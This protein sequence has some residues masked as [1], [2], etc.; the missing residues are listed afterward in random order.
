MRNGAGILLSVLLL[1]AAA[2]QPALAQHRGGYL[3][4][5]GFFIGLGAGY[6]SLG[7]SC[8]GCSTDR[9]GGLSGNLRLGGTLN[10]HLTAGV[11][12]DGFTKSGGSLGDGV[13]ETGGQVGLVGYYYPSPT[14]NVYL[15]GSLGLSLFK[16][17]DK[18][19]VSL[20]NPGDHIDANGLGFGVGVGYD[21]YISRT[22]S[23]T[24]YFNYLVALSGN[25]KYNGTAVSPSQT[26]KPNMWQVG[27][28]IIWH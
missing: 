11:E 13:T 10:P 2:S 8:N 19:G 7:A 24:P 3:A 6:G 14:G 12:T 25:L 18:N 20:P 26:V 21:L 23:L 9:D 22:A 28:A 4:R 1:G 5:K 27:V 16:I 15:R 17:T